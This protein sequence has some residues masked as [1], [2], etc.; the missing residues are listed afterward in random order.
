[1]SLLMNGFRIN[2]SEKKI[3]EL[4]F[5]KKKLSK[6]L[7]IDLDPGSGSTSKLNGS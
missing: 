2:I 3:W 5:V 7:R 4:I 6:S 1:M